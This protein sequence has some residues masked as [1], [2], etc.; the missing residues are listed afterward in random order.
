MSQDIFKSVGL[1]VVIGFVVYLVVKSL[2]LQTSLIE[3]LTLGEGIVN[4]VGSSSS[5][6]STKNQAGGASE[7]GKTI[8][9]QF[10]QLM[11]GFNV[12]KYRVDYENVIIQMSDYLN[13]LV[14]QNILSID[15][16][17]MSQQEIVNAISNVN[18]LSSGIATLN[19]TLKFVD[20]N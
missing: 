4:T 2:S 5:S 10:T 12:T 9:Q 13:A 1:V 6:R 11:D 7:F 14:L 20:S 19:S 16:S 3:G 17:A 15:L 18:T 8:H